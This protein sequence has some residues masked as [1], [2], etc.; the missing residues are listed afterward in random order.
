MAYLLITDAHKKILQIILQICSHLT[1]KS[2]LAKALG[3]KKE[4][5]MQSR[6]KVIN[7]FIA[8][9]II[10]LVQ[11]RSIHFVQTKI[12]IQMSLI[13]IINKFMINI[14]VIYIYS[15]MAPLQVT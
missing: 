9:I 12:E 2:Q 4:N 14:E 10:I 7:M 8:W 13:L 11:Q 3:V 5:K 15:P 1:V 6:K